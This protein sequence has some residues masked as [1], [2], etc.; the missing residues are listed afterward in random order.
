MEFPKHYDFGFATKIVAWFLTSNMPLV[1]ILFSFLVGAAALIVT[2]REEEPQIT[3]PMAD[4]FVHIPGAEPEKVEALIGSRL[5]KLLMEIDG[6]ENVYMVAQPGYAMVTAQFFVGEDR[7]RSLVKLFNKL[8]S[9]KDKVPEAVKGWVVKPVEIDDVPIVNFTLYNM[10]GR[11]SDYELRRVAEELRYNLQTV[12]EIG[13]SYIMG[14]RSRQVRIKLSAERL[15]AYS[16]TPSDVVGALRAANVKLPAGS[17]IALNEETPLEAGAFIETL[18]ALGDLVVTVRGNQ[19]VYV[20]DVATITDGPAEVKS[21]TW[22]GFGSASTSGLPTVATLPKGAQIGDLYPAVTVAFAKKKGTNAV[23]AAEALIKQMDALQAKLIPNG[24]EYV[25]SR[26]YGETANEKVNNL[27]M[28]LFMAVVTIL[29]LLFATLGWRLALVVGLAVPMTLAFTLLANYLLGFTINRVTLFALILALGTLVDDPVVGAENIYRHFRL[30]KDPPKLAALVGMDEVL[31]PS[32][33]ATL[34]IIASFLPMLLVT[35]MMGPYMSPMPLTVSI[36][37]AMSTVVAITVTPWATFH[38]LKHEYG[39][40]NLPADDPEATAFGRFYRAVTGFLI[41]KTWRGWTFLGVIGAL[42]AFSL[43][44]PVLGFVPLKMLPFD[45]KDELQL[46]V[47]MPEGT[48]LE[49][50][51]RVARELARLMGRQNEVESYQVFVGVPSP[52]DFNGLV[53]HYYVRK[54]P[55]MADI[56]LNL[57]PRRTRAQGSHEMALRIRPDVDALAKKYGANIKIVESPPGPPVLATGVAEV[58]AQPWVSL[59]ELHH[60]TRQVEAVFHDTE[61]FE[62]ID[63]MIDAERDRL[64]LELDREKAALHAVAEAHLA[65]MLAI[66]SGSATGQAGYFRLVRERNPLPFKVELPRAERNNVDDLLRMEIRGADGSMVPL[67][68][69]VHVRTVPVSPSVY[70]KN[71][72]RIQFVT[73][74]VCGVSPYIP[75]LEAQSK[76][77]KLD[78]PEGVRINWVGEGEW[79]ITIDVFRDMGIAY[80][81]GLMGIFILLLIQTNSF[82][83]PMIIMSAIPL[84]MIGIMPG[85]AF[86][87]FLFTANVSG[88]ESPIFFTA[89]GMIGMI[90]LAG[91]VVRNSI[92]LIDFIEREVASGT[93]FGES[94]IRAGII[95]FRPIMLTAIS[96]L[97]GSWV[98]ALDPIFS[99]L[100]WSFIFGIFAST[101]F[102]LFVIPVIYYL[103][104]HKNPPTCAPK[105]PDHW[106]E[107]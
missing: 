102:T 47:D 16:L 80:V 18:Q 87:N 56:R 99:G 10:D 28:S 24:V 37:I 79:K 35:G 51:D 6:V 57:A 12:P 45:N 77:S 2:P 54:G 86:L 72:E 71:G 42:F 7:E 78:L 100:A 98:I 1:L 81:M 84:T 69:L 49:Q 50:T 11:Y 63:T 68:E 59:E 38:M 5:G 29:I 31:P 55:H 13:K 88:Y 40:D 19:P 62:D 107:C 20:R 83:M 95:R 8:E 21:Y 70:Q 17:S 14:G 48:A 22:N 94:I 93:E 25:V 43:A 44:L 4:V 66:A 97:F 76:V 32:I 46:I 90:A 3:V 52:M 9:N 30:R 65:E 75:I 106:L 27:V 91:I 74:E 89:T 92:V 23:D 58:I 101:L 15:S 26:D 36:A 64:R 61:G 60:V 73:A 53:R 34:T 82:I 67:S 85:F 105:G 104:F 33:V 39:D 96:S 103:L 41:G